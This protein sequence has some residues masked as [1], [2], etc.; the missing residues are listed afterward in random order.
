M[1]QFIGERLVS[2][3]EPW[4]GDCEENSMILEFESGSIRIMAVDY[5]EPGQGGSP[6]I[7][8]EKP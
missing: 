5:S 4:D 2:I 6:S 3:T 8:W 1:N 7:R